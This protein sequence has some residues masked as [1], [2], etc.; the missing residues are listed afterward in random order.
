M[1]VKTQGKESRKGEFSINRNR[2]IM[3]I[4]KNVFDEM[5]LQK[6]KCFVIPTCPD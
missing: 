3:R 4:M 5:L 2:H 6:A 1:K